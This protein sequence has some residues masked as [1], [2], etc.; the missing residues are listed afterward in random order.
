MIRENGTTTTKEYSALFEQQLNEIKG[1]Q[2]LFAYCK[3]V[4]SQIK[5]DLPPGRYRGLNTI[6]RYKVL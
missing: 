2:N 4:S 3:E 5:L 6:I 1:V